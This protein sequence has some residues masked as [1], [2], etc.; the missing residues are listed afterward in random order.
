M[1]KKYQIPQ[2]SLVKASNNYRTHNSQY[3]H[4]H[5]VA[6]GIRSKVQSA[7]KSVPVVPGIS[8]NSAPSLVSDVT[9]ILPG[10]NV[11]G[12][13][14]PANRSDEPI[15]VEDFH[16]GLHNKNHKGDGTPAH[17]DCQICISKSETFK[18]DFQKH[19]ECKVCTSILL[20]DQVQQ[21]YHR[22]HKSTTIFMCSVCDDSPV[23]THHLQLKR[24][25]GK[26]IYCDG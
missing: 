2:P 22:Y 19:L 21:H 12:Y 5:N 1:E 9:G 3:P 8:S 24:H 23:F 25:L 15:I 16:Y 14:Y 18:P 4:L 10:R 6:C 20:R 13:I 17:S 11:S 7:L 26:H